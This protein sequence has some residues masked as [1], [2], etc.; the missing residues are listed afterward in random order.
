MVIL[1]IAL[2]STHIRHVP[3]FLG[4]KITRTAQG[5]RDSQT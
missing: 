3:S 4:T 1:L 2:Q 5:L